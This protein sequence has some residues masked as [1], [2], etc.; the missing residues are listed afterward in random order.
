L[1]AWFYGTDREGMAKALNLRP[2]QRV[3]YG[4]AVGLPK[5]KIARAVAQAKYLPGTT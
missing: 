5:E 1:N 2:G 4:Q 3:L